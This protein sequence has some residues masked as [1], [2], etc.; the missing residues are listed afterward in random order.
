MHTN[1]DVAVKLLQDSANFYQMLADKNPHMR[2]DMARN[3]RI[4]RL[5]AASLAKSPTASFALSEIEGDAIERNEND[6]NDTGNPVDDVMTRGL[7]GPLREL[8]EF[9]RIRDK[10]EEQLGNKDPSQGDAEPSSFGGRDNQRISIT[11][12]E[13]IENALRAKITARIDTD[14]LSRLAPPFIADWQPIEPQDAQDILTG[15]TRKLVLDGVEAPWPLEHRQVA[16]RCTPLTFYGQALFVDAVVRH[17]TGM[18]GQ[19]AFVVLEGR[20]APLTVASEQVHELNEQAPLDLKSDEQAKHYLR[21]FCWVVCGEEGPF[22][23]IEASEGFAE[24]ADPQQQALIDKHIPL[25]VTRAD[26]PEDGWKLRALVRY[27]NALFGAHFTVTPDGLIEM[28][29]DVPIME[30]TKGPLAWHLDEEV[31]YVDTEAGYA[32]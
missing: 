7:L 31:R 1:A 28:T 25:S 26:P 12:D 5:V 13:E 8:E 14:L 11:M 30:L 15:L 17:R 24:N 21:Y 6:D 10:G 19:V 23:V 18:L 22:A 32:Q 2:R 20:M 4:Y 29:D 9:G 16:L 3:S 27:G